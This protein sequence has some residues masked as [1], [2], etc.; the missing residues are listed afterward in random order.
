M[1]KPI[2]LN[3]MTH[4]LITFI[5][6]NL[7]ICAFA[8]ASEPLPVEAF[9]RLPD[10]TQL[11]ISP[12]GNKV[13][14]VIRYETEEK[15]GVVIQSVNLLTGKKNIL[16]STDNSKYVVKWLDWANNDILLLST[17]YPSKIYRTPITSTRLLR[18]DT[19]TGEVTPAIPARLVRRIDYVPAVQDRII[20][21]L[22][23]NPDEFIISLRTSNA[24]NSSVFKVNH[25]LGKAKKLHASRAKTLYWMTDQQHQLRIARYFNDT[26]TRY[27]HRSDDESKWSTLFEHQAFSPTARH[28]LGFDQDPNILYYIGLYEGRSA[29]FKTDLSKESMDPELVYSDPNYDVVGALLYSHKNRRVVGISHSSG[30]GFTFWD[31][32]YALLQRSLNKALPNTNNKIIGFSNDERRALVLSA[33][34]TNSGM[35]YLWD[36]DKKTMRFLASRYKT[37]VPELMASKE[38]ISYAARD[39]LKISGFLTRPKN[40]TVEPGPTI[41]F[42]HGGPISYDGRG[43]DYWTQYFANRGY[44]V[45]Q[46]NFRG[47]FGYGHDFMVAGLKDWGGKMQT[48]VE[49][50]TRWLIKEKIAD[51][52]KIC[53][54]GASYG[55]YAALM[56][57]ANNSKLYQCAVSFAGVTYLPN[58]L[59]NSGRY[60]NHEVVKEQIGFERKELRK[61]S[62]V[63]RASEIDIPILLAHGT[64]DRSVPIYQGRRMYKKLTKAGRDVTYL[65]F[66]DGTHY[67]SN[68]N[69]RVAFFKK[70]DTFLNKHLN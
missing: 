55:G 13:V 32:E 63:N 20:D 31:D 50:G 30:D 65:E 15:K 27:D 69:H 14:S 64:K 35:Y 25:R 19:N 37:L 23:D 1:D 48:D 9:S 52:N 60:I 59:A 12:D 38:Y 17:R 6:F 39:G 18:I 7:A 49:D 22:P 41:I 28:P 66:E 61:R 10:V 8:Q 57:A 26:T 4:K 45:L 33:S 53:I 11:S 47:S 29:V 40:K 34:D 58:L 43:F 24:V 51:P 5:L 2:Q 54:V 46:M 21:T 16:L 68:E 36:R 3:I 70:M 62:P 42:P 67:L 56:E 44:N